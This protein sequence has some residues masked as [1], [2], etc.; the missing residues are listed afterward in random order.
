MIEILYTT[1]SINMAVVYGRHAGRHGPTRANE[2]TTAP[3]ERNL[4]IIYFYVSSFIGLSLY[5][6]RIDAPMV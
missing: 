3:R 5:L 6:G 1:Q 2:T 4:I